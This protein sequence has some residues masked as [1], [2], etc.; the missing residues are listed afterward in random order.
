MVNQEKMNYDN[1]SEMFVQNSVR[2]WL[3]KNNWK[4]QKIVSGSEKGVDIIAKPKYGR[5]FFIEAKG[6]NNSS[7]SEVAFIYSLGQIITRMNTSGTTRYYYGLALPERSAKIALRR[8]PPQVARKLLLHLFSV[9]K[10]GKVQLFVVKGS[11]KN[12]KWNE[13]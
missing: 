6:S 4:I 9:G 12:L 11:G 3:L 1:I 7:S 2:K 5:R 8:L 10:K 13:K